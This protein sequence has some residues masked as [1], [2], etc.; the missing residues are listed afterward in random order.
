[1]TNGLQASHQ[2]SAAAVDDR[3]G[4]EQGT[5]AIDVPC[6]LSGH[7]QALQILGIVNRLSLDHVIHDEAF[8]TLVNLLTRSRRA[9]GLLFE[10][11]RSRCGIA[12]ESA[13]KRLQPT[14]LMPS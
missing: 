8:P 14:R 5:H 7:Q 13:R 12:R 10:M 3:V 4:L 11:T 2:P 1:T 6:I 9:L